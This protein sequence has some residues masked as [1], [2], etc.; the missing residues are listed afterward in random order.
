MK[1]KTAYA[2]LVLRIFF[3]VAF[4]VAGLDKV[5]HYSMARD[6]MF[7]QWFGGLGTVML[8]LAILI[9]IA[10]GL[11]LLTGYYARYA[12][13]ALIPMMLVAVL[14]TWKIGGMDS[15]SSLREI[16]VMNTGGGNTA[17]NFAYLAGLSALALLLEK[18]K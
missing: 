8:M 9:E 15:I 14:V 17:V 11:A 2:I 1:D 3:G 6:M 16:L 13:W 12:T 7:N 4:L 18:Q 5:L 10:G